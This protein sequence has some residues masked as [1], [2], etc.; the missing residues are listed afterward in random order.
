MPLEFTPLLRLKCCTMCVTN[1]TPR[2]SLSY[3]L[4][5]YII[6]QR[7]RCE[8]GVLDAAGECYLKAGLQRV[9]GCSNCTSCTLP[10]HN[11]TSFEFGPSQFRLQFNALTLGLQ[12]ISVSSDD[13]AF[14]QGFIM[15]DVMPP[16]RTE[17]LLWRL[18]I[19]DCRTTLPE[20]VTVTSCINADCGNTSHTTSLDGRT[21]TLRW[22]GV[23]LPSQFAGIRLDV[24]VTATQLAGSKPGIALRG[25]VGLSA[26][27]TAQRGQS[28]VKDVCL[29]NM[30]LPTLD[31]I[32]M[33]SEHTAR[34]AFYDRHLHSRM[35]LVPTPTH[36]KLLQACDQWHPSRVSTFLTSSRC[37]LH[38]NTEGCHVHS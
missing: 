36:L 17:Y 37:K 18:N 1:G 20:G 31:G 9:V 29:Q 26:S 35:P 8:A 15:N 30:A 5:L 16:K 38:P 25:A 13:G 11:T 21:L 28:V 34:C 6:P 33:R 22:V 3:R 4:T 23:P 27:S 19:S 2:M 32:P 24:T 14:T 12:N 10:G 7:C